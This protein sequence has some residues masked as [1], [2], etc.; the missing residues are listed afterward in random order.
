VSGQD[1][2]AFS[3][4]RNSCYVG[5]DI[6]I[7][8]DLYSLHFCIA[9]VSPEFEVIMENMNKIGIV[10]TFHF[11]EESKALFLEE[12]RTRESLVSEPSIVDK[13][14]RLQWFFFEEGEKLRA[15]VF[16]RDPTIN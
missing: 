6:I 2:C 9:N 1:R 13:L 16:I 4:G 5:L 14:R 15:S 11:G 10:N 3:R 8:N 7:K 12:I